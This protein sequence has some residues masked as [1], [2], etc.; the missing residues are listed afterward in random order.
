M[1]IPK[2]FGLRKSGIYCITNTVNKKQYIGS[3]K[4]IYYRL[5]RHQSELRRGI[6]ANPYLLNSYIKYGAN[7]FTVSI[8]EEVPLEL[9]T[10]KEQE[11]IDNIKPVYN[12]TLEVVRNTPSIESRKK[13]SETLKK[14]KE[15]GILKYPTHDDKKKPVIIYDADCNCIGKYESESSAAKKLEELYP[16]LKHSQAVV[17]LRV[18]LKNKRAKRKIYK[19]HFLLRPD[20]KCSNEKLFR[21]NGFKIKVTNILN[22]VELTF[23]TMM[24]AARTIGCCETA[25]KR[26]LIKSR[27]LLKQYKVVRL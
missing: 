24:E 7:F 21:A 22:N 17:N 9:L 15:L 26:A 11:Y 13:I 14:Q 2:S 20:E 10:K 25:V 1:L 6:H 19:K 3:S 23:P 12:I 4:N 5:K 8:L 27:L 16:G 18:N